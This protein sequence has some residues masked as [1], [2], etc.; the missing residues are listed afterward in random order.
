MILM[1]K[2][3]TEVRFICETE[4]GYSESQGASNIDTVIEKSWNKI[5]GDFPIYDETYRKILCCKILKH[6]Y[7]REIASETAGI[8]KMWLTERMNMIM[9]YYNQLYISTTLEF[10]PMYDVDLNTTHNLKDEG[11]NSSSIH[12]EDS[13]TRTDNLSSLRTDALK[14]TDENNQW[15]KYSD[16]PQGAL[17]GV[18]SGEY[19]TDARNITDNGS[20][21]DTGTQKIDNTGTQVNSG[22]TDST[23][24]GNYSSLK[25]YVEHVQGKRSGVTYSKMLME[26]R[27]TMLNIDQMIIGELSDL[28]FLL[29]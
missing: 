29:W 12:G 6:F 17:T 27:D 1:S 19:L 8:W 3:T 24:N 11:N 18:E 9:P 2:Y 22:T 26:Y 28:F 10:N 15:N 23:S 20:S 16:T 14:H 25:E 4:A 21:S 5:F 13:N 7:L